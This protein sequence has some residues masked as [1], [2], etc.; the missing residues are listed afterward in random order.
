MRLTLLYTGLFAAG[1]AILL[2]ITYLLVAAIPTAVTSWSVRLP[3][4][5]V[6]T[7]AFRVPDRAEFE[8]ICVEA[9]RSKDVDPNLRDKCVTAYQVWGAQTQRAETLSQ[10]LRFSLTTLAAVIG[11]AAL[12]GWIVAGRVLRPVHTIAAA[13]RAASQRNLSDRI[14]LQGPHDELRDLADT[15]DEMLDRLQATFVGQERFIANASHELR[16]PLMAMRATVDVVLAKPA[17]TNAELCEM[18]QDVRIEVDHAEGL[19]EALLTLARNE[20]GLMVSEDV[21]LATAAEDVLDSAELS[22]RHVHASLEPAATSGDPVLLERLIANLVD[23]AVRYN[24]TGGDVWVSTSTAHGRPTVVVANTG[25]VVPTEAIDGLFEPF[26]R[27]N[28]RTSGDGFG[29]GLA[30]VASIATMHHGT[31]TA[32]PRPGGGLHVTLALPPAAGSGQCGDAA[33][34]VGAASS[35]RL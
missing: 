3:G 17:P 20:R 21:D 1:G 15:F 12:T 8:P 27:L 30:I 18:A 5:Q 11:L 34:H 13:A 28:D 22:D 26:H 35:Y 33:H 7:S 23:N 14:A 10:L 31:V 32:V 29:L 6:E 9:L 4:G 25:P 24:V 16:T 2:V 19:V